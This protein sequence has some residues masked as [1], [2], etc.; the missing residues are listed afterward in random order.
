[1]KTYNVLIIG[2]EHETCNITLGEFEFDQL[3]EINIQDGDFKSCCHKLIDADIIVTLNEW[4][5]DRESTS[6]LAIA[7]I[8][9]KEVVPNTNFVK[10]VQQLHD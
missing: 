9:G 2:P 1:M 8:M 3:N 6:L 4:Q 7:R 10:Y 5:L